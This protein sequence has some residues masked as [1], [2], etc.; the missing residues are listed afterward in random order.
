ML[1]VFRHTGFPISSTVEYG[2]VTLHF[3]I[4]PSDAYKAALADREV[5]RQWQEST[6]SI[7]HDAG[8]A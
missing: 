5:T 8:E 1:D 7:A 4:E 3:P 6:P 2:T